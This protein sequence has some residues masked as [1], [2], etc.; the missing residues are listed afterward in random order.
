MVYTICAAPIFTSEAWLLKNQSKNLFIE[1]FILTQEDPDP[2]TVPTDLAETKGPEHVKQALEV[3][4]AGGHTMLMCY[5]QLPAPQFTH[6][7]MIW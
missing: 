7:L 4:A 6:R 5:C 2:P 3:A 1:P